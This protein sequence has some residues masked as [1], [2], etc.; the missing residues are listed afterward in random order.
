MENENFP[1]LLALRPE[2]WLAG[3]TGVWQEGVEEVIL[4]AVLPMLGSPDV[5]ATELKT[6]ADV[7]DPE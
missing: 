7:N 1:T 5:A 3:E 4:L 2:D 6:V